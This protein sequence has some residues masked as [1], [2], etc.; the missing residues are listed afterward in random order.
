MA[1]RLTV[2][3][4]FT[5]ILKLAVTRRL[6]VTRRTSVSLIDGF[7]LGIRLGFRKP[8]RP[9]GGGACPGHS[10]EYGPF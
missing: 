5:V 2:T 4:K 7:A 10:G 3:R 1:H 6:T 8:P 9:S